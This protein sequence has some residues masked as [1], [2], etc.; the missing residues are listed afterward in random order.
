MSS[1]LRVK[2]KKEGK[3]VVKGKLVIEGKLV[4]EG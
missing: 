1:L 3:H 4:V 2:L